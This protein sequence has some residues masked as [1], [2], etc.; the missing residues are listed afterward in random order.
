MSELC[1]T[2]VRAL[3]L[4]LGFIPVILWFFVGTR[5]ALS[6]VVVF[7]LPFPSI[8]TTF[9]IIPTTL[10]YRFVRD[11][12]SLHHGKVFLSYAIK[13]NGGLFT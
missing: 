5:M 3:G 8:V 11:S 2:I 13:A 1:D 4:M 9:V 10:N 7:R 6:R 12:S